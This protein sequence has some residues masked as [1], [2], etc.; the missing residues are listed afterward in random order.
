MGPTE[1]A[2]MLVLS[3]LWGS[4]F[5]FYKVLVTQVPPFSVVLGRVGLAAILLNIVVRARGNTMPR[6]PRL[7]GSFVALG[8]LNN[9]VPFTLLA[10]GETRISSGMAA[11][12]NA[13]TPL[14]GIVIAHFV[15]VDEKLSWA[16]AIGVMLGIAGVAT[17]MRPDTFQQGAGDELIGEAACLGAALTYAVGSLFGRRFRGMPPLTVATGQLTGSTLV[18]LPLSAIFD[19]PWT[20]LMPGPT[21][22]LA[23]G[24]I[25]LFSTALAYVLYFRALATAGA[26]NLLY[27]TFL[28][29]VSAI[30]LGVTFL[31]EA[32]TSRTLAGMALIGLGL[33][34]LDGKLLRKLVKP[35][36]RRA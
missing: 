17:L 21:V 10:F 20:I 7:W 18:L 25:A 24:G 29:P 19:R 36:R 30:G 34:A 13:T 9:V 6:D 22:W 33:G 14:F 26:T 8:M 23:F 5:F 4:S 1:W 16:K 28:L 31:G 3:A 32:V 27:I 35:N 15:T 11:I 12:L 2:L